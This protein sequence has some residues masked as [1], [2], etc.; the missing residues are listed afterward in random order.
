MRPPPD[1]FF[2][3]SGGTARSLC[4]HLGVQALG[5]CLW[6]PPPDSFILKGANKINTLSDIDSHLWLQDL[7]SWNCVVKTFKC[8]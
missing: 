8:D 3:L 5:F 2:L 1:L 4:A 7:L 6:K